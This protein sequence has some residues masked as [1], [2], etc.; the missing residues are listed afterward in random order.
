MNESMPRIAVVMGGPSDEHDV[1]LESGSQVLAALESRTP[2]AVVVQRDGV[3]TIDGEI[4]RSTGAALERLAREVDVVFVALH[5]PFGEDGTVQ[6]LFDAIH[7]PY[8][9]SGVAGSALAMDK[10]RAKFVYVARE[11]PTPRF[12][13]VLR[14]EEWD[15]EK[16]EA[17]C[18][19][20][21]VV[22]PNANGSSFGVSFPADRAALVAAIEA[23]VS[24]GREVLIERRVVGRELTCGVLEM[25][26]QLVAMPVTE[27][28]PDSKYSF[29]DYEAKYTPGAT[30]EITP[31]KIDDA[32][33][34]RVQALAR[35]A[36]RAL[37]C[38]DFSRTDVMV[39]PDRGPVV[40]ETNTVPGLTRQSL[41][42]Q[43]AAAH[44][45]PFP[46]LVEILVANAL[47][48][49]PNAHPVN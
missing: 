17:C 24:A 34:D 6:A 37:G 8:T 44:G 39:D 19:Y 13:T 32:L 18:D 38:R 31:A 47:Q 10:A 49:A 1:S 2:L 21:C 15:V 28:I 40:L 14:G 9:G 46:R 12:A 29:F 42:P 16:I 23:H 48:R 30:A 45:I 22:K 26:G 3:W 36:H 41:F 43:A 35:A 20:P 33:R 27:I 5:G 11:I 25:D 7:L 4:A